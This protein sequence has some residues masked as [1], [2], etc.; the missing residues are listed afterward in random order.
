MTE[1]IIPGTYITVRTEGLIS[2][3]RIATGIVGV[4]GTAARGP[5]GEPITLA[6]FGEARELFGQPDDF[7][8]P[9]DGSNP[10]TLVRSLEHIYNNGAATVVAVRVG[11]TKRTASSYAV[12]DHNGLTIATMVAKTPGSWGN[13]IKVDIDPAENEC[14]ISDET[15]TSGFASLNYARI[16][17]SAENRIRIFR[18]I[19]QRFETLNI[20][21]KLVIED[22]EVVRQ[23]APPNYQ[24][25][26]TP[27]E[28]VNDVNHIR[29]LDSDGNLVREYDAG[30]ILYNSGSP[31]AAGEVNVMTASGAL[32]FGTTPA[33]DQIVIATYAA[34]HPA[35]AAGEVLVTTWDGQLAFATGGAPLQA[36]GDRLVA[37]YLVDRED[38]AQLTL[39]YDV[40][41]ET[42]T[43]VDGVLLA[44]LVNAGSSLASAT[45]HVTNGGNKPQTAVTAYFGTGSNIPGSNGADAG[46]AEY[47]LGL[48]ALSNMLINIVVLAG[49]D[50]AKM[51]SVLE[52][53]LRATESTDLERIGVIGAP[54][55]TLAEQLGHNVAMDRI[56]LVA[57][58]L[59]YPD[60]LQLPPAYTAAAVAGL[61]SSLPV[62]TSLTNKTLTIP[63]L[64]ASFNRGQQIQ[65]IKR[66]VLAVVAKSGFRVLKGVTTEGEG[67]PFSAIPTRRI[68][69]YA[70]Y[71]VR[72][73][74]NPYIG[75][76]NNSR[77]RAALQ[78]TLEGFLTS[79]VED[80]ALTG[81]ELSVSATRA[82]EIAGEVSVVM[83]LQP[84][85]SIDY[86][87]VVM[88]L[89]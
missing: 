13:S 30:D 23:P 63:G 64:G 37:S 22:E 5:V 16:V 8:R 32:T 51:G 61:I 71:G 42:F 57:P 10:L 38:C 47:A 24:L 14:R 55:S 70:K 39:T 18:G 60:G 53:H 85:F 40:G 66:N 48:E 65:L 72:S 76:L 45:A 36:N 58:G 9:E 12:L 49:Q 79:M 3:A 83:T 73:A 15:H 1:M 59:S 11:S 17:P 2:A 7:T 35:P 44:Q 19:T 89:K 50:S 29:V 77:V 33:S 75:R 20:V 67:M 54:G 78:A 6:G 74:S 26:H 27:V 68:V 88:N 82:Q 62:M 34:G 80:E 84:T 81:F 86:I 69:D 87:R 4:V 21:Y 28:Q 31:P 56:I 25:A 43:V 41:K 52:A 46:S